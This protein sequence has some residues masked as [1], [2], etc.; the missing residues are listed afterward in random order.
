MAERRAHAIWEG[1]LASGSG[2]VDFASGAIEPQAVSWS[3]RAEESDGKTSPEELIAGAHAT[4][5]SMALAHGLAQAGT[6]ATRLETEAVCT[7]ERAEGGFAITSMKLALRGEVPG[8]D[9]AGFQ[10]AAEQAKE[11]CPVS[12]ALA[13]SVELTLDAALAGSPA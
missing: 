11:D 6:P 4:C 9:E 3:A 1:D 2:T 12:K 5:F 13:D 7:F 8:I 10:E